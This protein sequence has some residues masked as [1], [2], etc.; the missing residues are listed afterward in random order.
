MKQIKFSSLTDISRILKADKDSSFP[1]SV[2]SAQSAFDKFS[3][4]VDKD[5][6][7]TEIEQ[8]R[9]KLQHGQKLVAS[10]MATLDM[11]ATPRQ[12]RN[13]NYKR[14]VSSWLEQDSTTNMMVLN[15]TY[16]ALK[17]W[18]PS[19][20]MQASRDD[21]NIS[22]MILTTPAGRYGFKLTDD[23]RQQFFS[24]A[25]SHVLGDDLAD[26]D[27][28]KIILDSLEAAGDNLLVT[29]NEIHTALGAINSRRVDSV[30]EV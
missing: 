21:K 28:N 4:R 2:E 1:K 8:N 9:L 29:H 15:S 7:K 6:T 17:D 5:Q 10:L 16:S 20:L 23:Q 11:Q 27:N 24:D 3:V 12:E 14:R 13:T 22:K 19:E 18:K 26:F 25:V 30:P